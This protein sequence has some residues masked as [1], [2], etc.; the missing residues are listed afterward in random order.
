MKKYEV[1]VEKKLCKAITMMLS[2]FFMSDSVISM[3]YMYIQVQMILTACAVAIKQGLLWVTK[4]TT[5]NIIF[6]S[7]Y[8]NLEYIVFLFFFQ[9]DINRIKP[10]G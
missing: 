6:T 10:F 1:I 5:S 4:V 9:K 2:T 8:D 7:Q 3:E